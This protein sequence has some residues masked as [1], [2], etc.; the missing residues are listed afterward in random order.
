MIQ[1]TRCYL[2]GAVRQPGVGHRV[3]TLADH[4]ITPECFAVCSSWEERQ[5]SWFQVYTRLYARTFALVVSP[6]RLHV[7]PQ[8]LDTKRH[9][10]EEFGY[11]AVGLVIGPIFKAEVSLAGTSVVQENG[12]ELFAHFAL[13]RTELLPTKQMLKRPGP[14]TK[15]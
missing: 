15:S 5:L 1:K 11:S 10:F 9:P 6:L 12:M 8:R 3:C 13:Q 2:C 4:E 7:F 14:F